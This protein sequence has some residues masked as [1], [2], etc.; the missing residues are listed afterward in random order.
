M[1]DPP[2]S[3]GTLTSNRMKKQLIAERN[4][5]SPAWVNQAMPEL[6]Q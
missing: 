4:I 2:T 1:I 5:L 6:D 3:V